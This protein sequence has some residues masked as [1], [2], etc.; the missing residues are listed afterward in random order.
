M[1]VGMG[2]RKL[3]IS[4]IWNKEPSSIS[5]DTCYQYFVL[6]P[7]KA[8]SVASFAHRDHEAACTKCFGRYFNQN[9]TIPELA[10]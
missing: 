2:K 4:V 1:A 3:E 9:L 7:L 10:K 6:V 5:Y 8:L